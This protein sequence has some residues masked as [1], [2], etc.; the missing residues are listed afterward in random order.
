MKTS[1]YSVNLISGYFPRLS[2][3]FRTI[4]SCPQPRKTLVEIVDLVYGDYVEN[5]SL[6]QGFRQNC[7]WGVTCLIVHLRVKESLFLVGNRLAELSRTI[8]TTSF[9]EKQIEINKFQTIFKNFRGFLTE[10]AI[11]ST[12]QKRWSNFRSDLTSP[13]PFVQD[14][15]QWARGSVERRAP[16]SSK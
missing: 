15:A 3:S 16:E 5:G 11:L 4:T 1:Y 8:T 12:M 6:R 10:I 14:L 9:N 13:S 2:T 7:R